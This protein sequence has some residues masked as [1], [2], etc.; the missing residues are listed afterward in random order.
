M[1]FL[2]ETGTALSSTCDRWRPWSA[3]LGLP[4][5]VSTGDMV[6]I[7]ITHLKERSEGVIV[8]DRLSRAPPLDM[9]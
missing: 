3:R 4:G 9:A 5:G 8:K 1:R 2:S 6:D 7:V